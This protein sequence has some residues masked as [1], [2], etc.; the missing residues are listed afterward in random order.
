MHIPAQ[1]A[2]EIRENYRRNLAAFP[3]QKTR[4]DAF[5]ARLSGEE[6]LCMQQLLGT[7]PAA[8]LLRYSPAVYYSYVKPTLT[9]CRRLKYAKELPPALLLTYVLPARVNNEALDGCRPALQAALLPLVQG[10]TLR[11]AILEVNYWCASQA[12][13][14]P[15]DDRTIGPAGFWRAGQGRC[16]EEST[17]A[18]C[19]LRA[20]G[21]PAR[22]CYSPRWAHC[23]DNHGWVEVWCPDGWHYLGACEPEPVLDRGWFTSAASR[24]MVI[25]AHAPGTLYCG[26]PTLDEDPRGRLVHSTGMY[27]ATAQLTVRL[28]RNGQPVPHRPVEFLLANEGQFFTLY[29][30]VTDQDGLLKFETGLG[31]LLVRAADGDAAV[32]ALADLRVARLVTLDLA[33]A[34]TPAQLA[35]TGRRLT[36]TPPAGN[37]LPPDPLPAAQQLAH[38]QRCAACESAHRS[39]SES[40][41]RGPKDAPLTL[42][43]G[44]R[45]Q[46]RAFLTDGRFDAADKAVLLSTLRPKDFLDTTA[47]VLADTLANALPHRAALPPEVWRAAV[48]APR[49]ANEP[50]T[51]LPSALRRAWQRIYAEEGQ[52]DGSAVW[53]TLQAHLK[54]PPTEAAAGGGISGQLAPCP[55]VCLESGLAPADGFD[56]VYVA[57]CRCLGIPARL[58]PLTG[59]PAWW[60]AGR[61][62]DAATAAPLPTAP[63]RLVNAARGPLAYGR[64]FTL[65]RWQNG[66]WHTLPAADVLPAALEQTGQ[67]VLPCGHYQLTAMIRQLDGTADIHQQWFTLAESDKPFVLAVAPPPDATVH[68]LKNVPIAQLLPGDLLPESPAGGVLIFAQPGAEPT[69]HLLHELLELRR[70]YNAAPYTLTVLCPVGGIN[71]PTLAQLTAAMPRVRLLLTPPE[72]TLT[73]LQKAMG[74]GDARL[75]FALAFDSHY[76]GLAAFANYNIDTAATLLHILHLTTQGGT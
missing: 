8:D 25:R 40:W 4:A 71:D 15:T 7:A 9:A 24:A 68:Y 11:E 5:C 75:P 28:L 21:I 49:I 34:R 35:G 57:V 66:G 48:L 20:V 38:A 67:T 74:Q 62:I 12:T 19:A 6:T 41:R 52:P 51:T 55:T 69:E 3:L 22:Q 13:Y 16:G 50:L 31:C 27:A 10:K 45:A 18:V 39:R 37:Q 2:A 17:F 23:D 30:G 47:D 46:I 64:Q 70:E 54:A 53:H 14:A 29:T 26:H 61:W 36:L 65:A 63:V 42:A 43:R 32:E 72:H 60:Q 1:L 58:D 59:Q 33:A 76:C 44:N 73:A 56:L